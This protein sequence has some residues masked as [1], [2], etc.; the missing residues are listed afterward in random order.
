MRKAPSKHAYVRLSVAAAAAAALTLGVLPSTSVAAPDDELS[1][2][3][4]KTKVK[5]AYH[6]AEQA[7]ERYHEISDKLSDVKSEVKALRKDVAREKKAYQKVRANVSETVSSRLTS[8]P[9][10]PTGKLLTSGDP[11]QFIDALSALQ[12]Y[13]TNQQERLRAFE[14]AAQEF[15][16][17]KQQLASKVSVVE[18]AEQKM[19]KEKKRREE[20]VAEAKNVLERLTAEQRERMERRRER[21]AERSAQAAENADSGDSGADSSSQN[22]DSGGN[23]QQDSAPSVSNASGKAKK[24]VQFALNQVGDAYSYGGTGPDAW[25]CSGLTSGAWGAAGVS[26]PRSSSAQAGVGQQ[27]STSNMSPGDLV[28]YYSPISHVG[29]YIG[30]GKLVHAPNPSS[31]VSVVPVDSMPITTVRRPG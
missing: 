11:D 22:S 4:A 21:A 13:S 15:K 23:D 6:Q 30:N 14:K 8:S 10:G 25:D 12:S 29:I 2:S 27:V 9:M 24:A 20:K 1:I 28:F 26:L 7:T 5:Q 16:V 3:E 19:A 17:R 31:S 18:E